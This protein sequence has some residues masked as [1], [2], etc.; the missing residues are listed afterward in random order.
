MITILDSAVSP[1]FLERR[2]GQLCRANFSQPSLAAAAGLN[3]A[4]PESTVQLGFFSSWI[5][6][7]FGFHCHRVFLIGGGLAM[8]FV[9]SRSHRIEP[10]PEPSFL[11]AGPVIRVRVQLRRFH[12]DL[13]LTQQSPCLSLRRD[14]HT[15]FQKSVTWLNENRYSILPAAKF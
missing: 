13:T 2:Y 10:L 6:A 9:L 14:I 7:I 3:S 15:D 1:P 8:S 5:A 4:T 11:G 12:F